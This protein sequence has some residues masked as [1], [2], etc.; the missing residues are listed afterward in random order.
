MD[1]KP[2]QSPI[3]EVVY[4]P[5]CLGDQPVWLMKFVFPEQELENS[6]KLRFWSE[7]LSIKTCISAIRANRASRYK[8]SN[9]N[10]ARLKNVNFLVF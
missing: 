3:G 6:R 4:K 7:F 1:S 8:L 2:F 9:K 10:F 5:P